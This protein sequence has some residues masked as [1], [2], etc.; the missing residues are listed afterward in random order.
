MRGNKKNYLRR[1]INCFFFDIGRTGGGRLLTTG[2]LTYLIVPTLGRNGAL[3]A[4]DSTGL[5][6]F[7]K[8]ITHNFRKKGK[9]QIL[10]KIP[11][12]GFSPPLK[13]LNTVKYF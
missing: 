8:P 10:A 12:K 2:Q 6:F 7:P 9:P 13:N 3:L 11:Y 5:P 1:R 4:L